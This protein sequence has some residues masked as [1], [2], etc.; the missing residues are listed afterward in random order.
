MWTTRNTTSSRRKP[1][2]WIAQ[3]L[4]PR[5]CSWNWQTHLCDLQ[6]R[7]LF[8]AVLEALRADPRVHILSADQSLLDRAIELYAN[9]RDK[10]WSSRAL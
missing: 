3:S 2:G 1:T 4:R 9:R 6:N 7:H 8:S 5:G 10:E